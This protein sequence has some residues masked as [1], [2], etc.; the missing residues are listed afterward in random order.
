MPSV[1]IQR[2]FDPEYEKIASEE[3]SL[4]EGSINARKVNIIK[5]CCG[6][7]LPCTV[8]I[9]S[10]IASLSLAIGI[11]A[12]VGYTGAWIVVISKCSESTNHTATELF[13]KMLCDIGSVVGILILYIGTPAV[14]LVGVSCSG[15]AGFAARDRV[16]EANQTNNRVDV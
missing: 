12:A 5:E 7:F 8:G 2:P 3:P 13:K 9:I 11:T 1:S 14:C 16:D 4:S 10:F 6:Q 15:L